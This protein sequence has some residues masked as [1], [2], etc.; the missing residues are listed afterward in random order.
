[1]FFHPNAPL[2]K[3][4]TKDI[5]SLISLIAPPIIN[6]GIK[7][8]ISIE[9]SGEGGE[10]MKKSTQKTVVRLAL[11]LLGLSLI[12]FGAYLL[13]R[14]LGW[15]DVSREGL[16]AFIAS[17]GVVA[18]LIFILISFLQ[19]TFVPIPGAVSTVAGCYVFGMWR[20]FL[21]SSIGMLLGSLLAFWLGKRIGR[22][23]VYW[24]V[25]GKEQTEEWLHRFKDR[26]KVLLFFKFDFI[27]LVWEFPR[28]VSSASY[29]CRFI[30]YRIATQDVIYCY[31]TVYI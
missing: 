15:T 8:I 18:P 21:Y 4:I 13:F 16:Q 10:V 31:S 14:A 29:L 3:L 26:E 12:L 7:I 9:A 24:L 23:F 27:G 5:P 17:R 30:Y 19:V 11:T 2:T 1:M 6:T 22:P 25:G 28:R 20:S